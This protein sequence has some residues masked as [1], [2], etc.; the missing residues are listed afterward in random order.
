[1]ALPNP[2][3]E[4]A[5]TN[6]GLSRRHTANNER[7]PYFGAKPHSLARAVPGYPHTFMSIPWGGEDRRAYFPSRSELATCINFDSKIA[8]SFQAHHAYTTT[9]CLPMLIAE[10]TMSRA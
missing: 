9:T 5:D 10:T 3:V 7:R 6:S 4:P 8:R 2:L 1:M